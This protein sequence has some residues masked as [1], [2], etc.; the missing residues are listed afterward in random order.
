MVIHG[1]GWSIVLHG[2]CWSMVIL[3][4]VWVDQWL[5]MV[6]VNQRLYVHGWF[7]QESTMIRVGQW[8]SLIRRG[9]L[10]SMTGVVQLSFM[11]GINH[12]WFF[13]S[14]IRDWSALIAIICQWLSV[15]IIQS[16]IILELNCCHPFFFYM[17]Y[18]KPNTADLIV[19]KCAKDDRYKTFPTTGSREPDCTIKYPDDFHPLVNYLPLLLADFSTIF[20]QITRLNLFYWPVLTLL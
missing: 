5:S 13:C 20:L 19:L 14:H 17:Q 8:S 12:P 11:I 4:M 1:L 3:S 2:L 6:W 9:P 16:T 7:G 15:M 10:S 18:C